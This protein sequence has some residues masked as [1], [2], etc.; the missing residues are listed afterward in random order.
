LKDGFRLA[1]GRLGLSNHSEDD[2]TCVPKDSY[3]ISFEKLSL[4]LTSVSS[5]LVK[6]VEKREFAGELM[7]VEK[8]EFA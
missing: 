8:Q 4:T 6:R 7:R 1:I 3:D 5:V 2:E